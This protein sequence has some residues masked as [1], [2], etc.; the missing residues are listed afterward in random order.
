[1]SCEEFS[2]DESMEPN[3]PGF[4]GRRL[5]DRFNSNG[6]RKSANTSVKF[7]KFRNSSN[8]K[9]KKTQ[10]N[11][12][13][14]SKNPFLELLRNVKKTKKEAKA[15]NGDIESSD[16]VD[17]EDP[18]PIFYDSQSKRI[19]S[20]SMNSLNKN[21]K[22]LSKNLFSSILQKKEEPSEAGGAKGS[23]D[24]NNK[25]KKEKDMRLLKL[26]KSGKK[27]MFA[28]RHKSKSNPE[29]KL[30]NKKQNIKDCPKI[31]AENSQDELP[32]SGF[33]S[34]RH[35]KKI[36][37]KLERKKK[38]KKKQNP[39]IIQHNSEKEIGGDV[40]IFMNIFTNIKDGI[41]EGIEKI[42][43]TKPKILTAKQ[44]ERRKQKQFIKEIKQKNKQMYK[45][46]EKLN[47][48]LVLKDF[49]S[50]LIPFYRPKGS[51]TSL[52]RYV[53]FILIA[54]REES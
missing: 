31:L 2:S 37:K 19:L 22:F 9:S 13:E 4:K 51:R 48:D 30:N 34:T 39:T 7:S 5:S 52:Y 29:S 23:N 33:S 53:A 20:K 26:K 16:C 14:K 18:K 32:E 40:N 47:F 25:K 24:K 12:G 41:V 46:S 42:T 3:S 43:N 10:K 45:N 1:M 35:L 27:S 44:I 50:I 54:Y 8:G 17:I 6:S 36:K 21:S 15:Q 38:K 11:C 49:I 28:I